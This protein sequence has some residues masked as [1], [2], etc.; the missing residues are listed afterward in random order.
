M[1]NNKSLNNEVELIKYSHK[2]TI[3]RD[4]HL[5]LQRAHD[6]TIVKKVEIIREQ[7]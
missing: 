7:L 5:F 3:F 4:V 6:T 1:L 2:K